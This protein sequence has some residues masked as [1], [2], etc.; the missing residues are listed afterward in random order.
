MLV[1][2]C[3]I[4][5]DYAYPFLVFTDADGAQ[6]TVSVASLEITFADGQLVAANGDGT[7]QLTLSEL[8]SMA[9]SQ[10]GEI[11]PVTPVKVESGLSFDGDGSEY[12]ATLG[13][14]FTGP[15]LDNPNALAVTWSSSDES[16]ATVDSEGNVTLVGAGT[17]TITVS[18][19]GNDTYEAGEA[20]YTLSVSEYDGV[21]S[22]SA[23]KPVKVYTAS[24]I[25]VGSFDSVAKAKAVLQKGLYVVSTSDKNHKLNIR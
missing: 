17:A 18:F 9:F 25:F 10:T 3:A 13:E 20:S 22:L 19:A 6:T 7:T 14:D 1:A 21:S 5:Q 2:F 15:T 23:H 8:A 16:V 12:A 11:A 4:A 24:G